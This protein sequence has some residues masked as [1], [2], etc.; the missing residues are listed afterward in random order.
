[1]TAPTRLRHAHQGACRTPLCWTQLR[2]IPSDVSF[3]MGQDL[4]FGIAP[5]PAT[6]ACCGS[7]PPRTE[8]MTGVFYRDRLS[9]NAPPISSCNFR[10]YNASGCSGLASNCSFAV[11]RNM[12]YPRESDRPMR[13]ACLP[14]YPGCPTQS[15]VQ[16]AAHPTHCRDPW[17][18][19]VLI[20]SCCP[21]T[22]V[23]YLFSRRRSSREAPRRL[24]TNASR[25]GRRV[26]GGGAA[27][28][29]Q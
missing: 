20:D 3:A 4:P 29:N 6:I 18:L 27:L 26:V 15:A 11:C 17:R 2:P 21:L 10:A 24:R 7:I 28:G 1:M 19:A 9:P 12:P 25:T 14:V 5:P 16:L 22:P 8:A 23:L 13:S